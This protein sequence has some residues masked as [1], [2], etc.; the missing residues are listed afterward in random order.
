[1]TDLTIYL[2]R[3]PNEAALAWDTRW[4]VATGGGEWRIADLAELGNVGGLA[5]SAPLETAVVNL[6]FTDRR[7][8]ADHP[9][10]KRAGGDLRGWW[11]DGVALDG[12]PPLGSFLW[13]VTDFGVASDAD[14]RWAEAFALE[15]LQPL[16]DAGVAARIVAQAQAAPARNR[17]DLSVSLY[18]RN[19]PRLY[20]QVFSH[21]WSALR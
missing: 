6:L 2:A 11:G 14:A 5:A 16:I 10:A 3:C 13:L 19:G 4:N 12:E 9:L 20:S 21:Y 1:M 15:A 7:C 18:G 8:P 17:L